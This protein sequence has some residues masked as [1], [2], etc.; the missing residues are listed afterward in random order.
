MKGPAESNA[1]DAF[2]NG[3]QSEPLQ[4]IAHHW[5][6]ARRDRRMPGWSDL[7]PSG[8]A[9]YLT[10]VWAFKYDRASG[11]F[12]S[13]LAGNRIMTGY[14]LSFRGTPLRDIHPPHMF[15]IAQE[16]MT[17]LVSEPALYYCSGK[18][19]RAGDR[20]VEGERIMM[21]LASDGSDADG[22]LG[23]TAYEYQNTG[24]KVEIVVGDIE[25]FSF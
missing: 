17:R 3:I 13:R 23:A 5:Q 24:E 16:H 20:V 2:V 21:P 8:M 6:A 7:S 19:F 22:A 18:L 9:P 14:G 25:W 4:A 15:K 1:F 10:M 11:E 12:T